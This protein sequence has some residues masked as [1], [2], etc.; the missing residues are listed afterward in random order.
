[1]TTQQVFDAVANREMTAE[2]GAEILCE[3]TRKAEVKA[4]MLGYLVLFAGF[5]VIFLV[6]P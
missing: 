2:Q 6:K 1:M 5:V 4:A 3:R